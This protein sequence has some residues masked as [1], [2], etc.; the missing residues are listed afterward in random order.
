M[1]S[2]VFLV[3]LSALLWWGFH[4]S[5]HEKDDTESEDV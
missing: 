1:F 5:E 3:V 4:S 2:I